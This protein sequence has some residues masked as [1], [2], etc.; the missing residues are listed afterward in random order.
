MAVLC[1][2]V[3]LIEI[4]VIRKLLFVGVKEKDRLIIL[5]PVN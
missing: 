1:C 2:L 4:F 3:S 5:L